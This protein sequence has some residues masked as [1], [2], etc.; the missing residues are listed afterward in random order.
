MTTVN[1]RTRAVPATTRLTFGGILASEWAKLRSLRSTWWALLIA[2]GLTV[3]VNALLTITLSGQVQ[4]GGAQPTTASVAAFL[5]T[6]TKF[7]QLA[8]AVLAVLTITSEYGT[9][10]IRSTFAAV[11]RRLPVL[12]AK[13]IVL[14]VLAFVVGVVTS[15]I[16]WAIA[17]LAYSAQSVGVSTSPGVGPVLWSV[18]GTGAYLGLCAVL[19]LGIGSVVRSTAAGVTIAVGLLFILPI[20]IQLLGNFTGAEWPPIVGTYLVDAAGLGMSGGVNGELTDVQSALVVLAWT[21][22]SF[23]ACAVVTR[24]RDV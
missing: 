9:G 17:V 7:G 10:L 6:G 18:L 23:G 13:G 4:E 5:T 12:A 8:I 19:S 15:G 21:A 20:V 22:I 1:A 3:G 14:F 11:P 24:S 2:A 16:S